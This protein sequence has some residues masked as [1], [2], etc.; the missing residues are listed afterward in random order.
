MWA[1]ATLFFLLFGDWVVLRLDDPYFGSSLFLLETLSFL[2]LIGMALVVRLKLFKE[3]GS[4]TRFGFITATV[5][6][7]LNT[8]IIW[9]RDEVFT[10][11][12]EGQ[13]HSFNVWMTL[14]CAMTL[15]VPAIID[16]LV[17]EPAKAEA[18]VE[19]VNPVSDEPVEAVGPETS[20]TQTEQV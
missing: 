8:F 14:A 10:A 19:V 1:F 9:Y 20:S 12:D 3:R 7:L 15:L 5:G 17:R 11:F 6:L 4:A 2:L 16:R 13:H 18:A